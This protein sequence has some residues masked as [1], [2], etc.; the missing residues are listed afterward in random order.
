[1]S[2]NLK[3]ENHIPL[4]ETDRPK[5][6]SRLRRNMYFRI[7]QAYRSLDRDDDLRAG[8]VYAAGSHFTS[9][10]ELTDWSD[11]FAA[12]PGL[13]M[14]VE[15][16][17]DP[18]CMMSEMRRR[19]PIVFAVHGYCYAWGGETILNADTRIAASD[20]RFG[21]LEVRRGFFPCGGAMLRLTKEMN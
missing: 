14:A 12:V 6:Y 5:K 15:G 18:F 21:M 20:T 7:D 3:K 8:V 19:K 10:L 2:I 11:R 4:M 13:A 9:G 17:I 16:E 1:M